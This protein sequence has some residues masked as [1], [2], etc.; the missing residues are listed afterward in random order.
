[1][2][3]LDLNLDVLGQQAAQGRL[4][5]GDHLPQIER[6]DLELLTPT[7][8]NELLDQLFTASHGRLQFLDVRGPLTVRLS[9]LIGE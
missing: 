6:L 8:G 4:E 5:V 1:M 9:Q 7:E 2:R 3:R